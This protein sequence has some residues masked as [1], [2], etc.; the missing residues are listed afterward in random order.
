MP[1]SVSL[2]TSSPLPQLPPLPLPLLQSPLLLL[3]SPL[4][5]M[6]LLSPLAPLS[7]SASA[8]RCQWRALTRLLGRCAPTW[9]WPCPG[10]FAPKLLS[11]SPH[12]PLPLPLPLSLSSEVL[13][14]A[15]LLSEVSVGLSGSIRCQRC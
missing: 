8:T 9:K 5:P 12:P 6:L 3:Q 14:L 7:Q 1:I 2:V 15:G 4:L 11:P 10:K 13:V